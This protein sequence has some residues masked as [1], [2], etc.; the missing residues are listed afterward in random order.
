M[1]VYTMRTS[2][3]SRHLRFVALVLLAGM[4]CSDSRP[5]PPAGPS[6][7]T[8]EATAV[9]SAPACQAVPEPVGIRQV[10]P[11]GGEVSAS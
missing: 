9:T 8:S 7:V 1:E 4:S 6:A 11:N 10:G 2:G 5:A 3:I